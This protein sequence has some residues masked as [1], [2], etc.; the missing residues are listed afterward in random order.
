MFHTEIGTFDVIGTDTTTL[1]SAWSAVF[2]DYYDGIVENRAANAFMECAQ[3]YIY[4]RQ[5]LA[6]IPGKQEGITNPLMEL[7]FDARSCSEHPDNTPLVK[8]ASAIELAQI[9]EPVLLQA[10]SNDVRYDAGNYKQWIQFQLS[11]RVTKE[12]T[13]RILAADR[14]PL[15]LIREAH[16]ILAPV[17]SSDAFSDLR[18]SAASIDLAQWHLSNCKKFFHSDVASYAIS[19]AYSL[20]RR[21][22]QYGI[23]MRGKAFTPHW[24]RI[25]AQYLPDIDQI[26]SATHEFNEFADWGAIVYALIE[27]G[28]VDRNA[29]AII[30]FLSSIRGSIQSG[31]FDLHRKTT[32]D[33][34]KIL[35]IAGKYAR[36]SRYA[37]FYTKLSSLR[38]EL[39]K[40]IPVVGETIAPVLG[41]VTF[42][43]NNRVIEMVDAKLTRMLMWDGY[44]KAFYIP[45]VVGDKPEDA[46]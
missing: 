21:G 36:F 17:I 37:P 32:K 27:E 13:S 2:P 29:N 45:K 12:Y 4:Y 43:G 6:P 5:L 31:N 1:Q 3:R 10:F 16:D 39:V 35:E 24:S 8:H 38:Q 34:V 15:E 30:D 22:R 26:E 23:S 40:A 7:W 46:G 25:A 18:A 44:Q 42:L 9:E 41:I 28:Y 20:F 14:D 11:S 19:Y 33:Q